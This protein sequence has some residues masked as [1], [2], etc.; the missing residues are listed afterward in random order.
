VGTISCHSVREQVAC[1]YLSID[2]RI[3]HTGDNFKGATGFSLTRAST[4]GANVRAGSIVRFLRRARYSFYKSSDGDWYLGYRRCSVGTPSSC[5]SIQPVSGPYRA[6]KGSN[7]PSGIAFR[8]FDANGAELTSSAQSA[9][10]SRV[11]IVL[12]GETAGNVAL[13]GDLR[14]TWRDSVI[15]SVSPRNRMR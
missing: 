3:H 5:A 9:S 6:Y 11:D 2:D 12:R 13:T 8:Y 4:P 1:D 7:S 15:V 14:K 10:V